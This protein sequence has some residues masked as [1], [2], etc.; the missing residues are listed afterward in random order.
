MGQIEGRCNRVKD[1]KTLLM[2]GASS[3]VGACYIHRYYEN[4]TH[5]WTHYGKS[6]ARVAQ[7]RNEFGEK[8]HPIQSDLQDAESV[9]SM[10]ETIERSGMIPNQIVHLAALKTEMKQFHKT[11]WIDFDAQL[12]VSLRSA[13]MILE[14]F[15]PLMRKRQ[16]GRVV[17]MLTD[18]VSRCVRPKY[19]SPYIVAKYALLVLMKDLV[20]EY[21]D[22]GITVNGISPDM[23]ETQ[24]LA[25]MDERVVQ[26]NAIENPLKRNI[27]VDDV[28]PLIAYLLS[29]EAMAITGENISVTGGI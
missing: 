19:Q 26:K 23:M 29:D 1:G 8:I 12:L 4:H 28:V 11:E 21:A 2:T 25:N 5:I 16:Y 17:F 6:E 13:V 9:R 20:Y 10:I 22:K 14:K 7:L 24:F 27:K 3:D 15:L 18:M